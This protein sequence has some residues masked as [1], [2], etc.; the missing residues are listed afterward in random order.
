LPYAWFHQQNVSNSIRQLADFLCHQKDELRDRQRLNFSFLNAIAFLIA[1]GRR[2]RA[3]GR[4]QRAEGFYVY[5]WYLVIS[6]IKS[7]LTFMATAIILKGIKNQQKTP[8]EANRL[9]WNF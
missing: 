5:D 8:R 6:A 1:K 4:G 7:A 2:K 3:E 9:G